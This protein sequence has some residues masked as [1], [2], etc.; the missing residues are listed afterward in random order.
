MQRHL[1]RG[2]G[3]AKGGSSASE[4]RCKVRASAPAQRLDPRVPA[5]PFRRHSFYRVGRR[6]LR[7]ATLITAPFRNEPPGVLL[8][9][10]AL[11]A[12]FALVL[13]L[14]KKHPACAGIL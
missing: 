12:T 11:I 1:T 7:H 10:V 2:L 9:Y 8:S 6:W 14:L 5:E 3:A 4:F 13:G